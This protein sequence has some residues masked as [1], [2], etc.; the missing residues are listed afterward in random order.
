[1]P[2]RKI[3]EPPPRPCTHPDHRPHGMRVYEP[4]TYEHEC[5]RCHQIVVFTVRDRWCYSTRR[6]PHETGGYRPS[7]PLPRSSCFA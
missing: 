3:G 2:T 6:W 7:G 4:G 5:P 1:M